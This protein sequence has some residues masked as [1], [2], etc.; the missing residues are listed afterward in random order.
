MY[1]YSE[2]KYAEPIY[3]SFEDCKAELKHLST[4]SKEINEVC[5]YLD[6]NDDERIIENTFNINIIKWV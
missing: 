3:D 5:S 1:Y 4:T 6:E 2:I